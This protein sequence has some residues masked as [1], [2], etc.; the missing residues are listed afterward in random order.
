MKTD[1][2]GGEVLDNDKLCV[3]SMDSAQLESVLLQALEHG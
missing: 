3:V 1:V 2:F